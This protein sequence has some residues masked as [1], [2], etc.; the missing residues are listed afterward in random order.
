MSTFPI[1]LN[2]NE[3]ILRSDEKANYAKNGPIGYNVI[4]GTL[5]LTSQ[6][7]VFQPSLFGGAVAYPLSHIVKASRSDQPI[8]K[9]SPAGNFVFNTTYK[10]GLHLE[11]D[12]GGMEY[13]IPEEIDAW[14]VAILEARSASPE[15]PYSKIPPTHSAVEKGSRGMWVML[16]VFGAIVL[17][18]LCSVAACLGMT[19]ILPLLAGSSK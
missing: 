9:A 19:F 4:S 17:L 12:N 7:I 13:F 14:A 16:G 8:Y 1:P 2:T 15:L 10:A 3:T 11:F 6:R 5:W 18:F